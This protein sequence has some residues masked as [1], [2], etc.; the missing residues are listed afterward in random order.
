ME[1]SLRFRILAGI[2]IFIAFLTVATKIIDPDFYWHLQDGKTILATHAVP[3]VDTY[4]YTM[5][6]APWVDHEW[7]VEAWMAWMWNHDLAW[8]LAVVFAVAAFIPFAV[9]LRRYRTWPDL[10]A[11]TAGAA[12]FVSFIAVRPQVFSYLFFFI[13]FALLSRYYGDGKDRT[14]RKKR[15]LAALPLIFFVWANIHAEFFSGLVLF[16]IFFLTD[17]AVT[18]WREKKI[19]WNDIP[20]ASAVLV[21]SAATPLFNPY[22]AGLYGEIFRVMLSGN[23]INYI[24]EWQSPFPMQTTFSPVTIATSF[25][26]SLFILLVIKFYKRLTPTTLVAGVI[27]FLLFAKAMRMGPLFIIIA[28]PLLCEGFTYASAGFSSRWHLVS[29][30]MKIFF[31]GIGLAVSVAAFG[32]IFFAPITLATSHYPA[33]AVA[34][35]N[36]GT[37]QGNHIVLLNYYDWGGYL[38]WNAPKIKVFID[39]RMPHWIAPDGTSAMEDYAAL[40]LTK[41]DPAAQ[42][43]I[44]KKWGINTI[45]IPSS[46][47]ASNNNDI[48][49][50]KGLRSTGWTLTYKDAVATILQCSVSSCNER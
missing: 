32:L 34:F 1:A 19:S 29:R 28:A 44:I 15:Y 42:Q 4:S 16:G 45:L 27:F 23:T 36:Q 8:A 50:I 41:P 18:T 17:T 2:L 49:L 20:F 5:T 30:R 40:F 38:I 11:I 7:L 12:L 43:A 33:N 24:Q 35:L 39:G 26:F 6:N 31:K 9:W 48:T 47:A 21:A 37:A 25:I 10:W 14:A 22:G 46:E 13:V 3:R